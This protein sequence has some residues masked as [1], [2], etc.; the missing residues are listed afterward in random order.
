MAN[1]TEGGAKVL[2]VDDNPAN[3]TAVEA[4]L[5]PL[6]VPLVMARSG[7]MALHELLEH[8]FAVVLLDVMMPGITGLDVARMMR[9]RERTRAVPII[10]LTA[11]DPDEQEIIEGYLQGAAD[12]LVK[13]FD[14][15]MLR[16]KVSVFV[17]L[18]RLRQADR[19]LAREEGLRARAEQE[20]RR[21]HRLLIHAPVAVAV[22]A[23]PDHT[24]ELA[25]ER[26]CRLANREIPVGRKLVEIFPELADSPLVKLL[27][28]IYEKREPFSATE[29]P[30]LFDRNR[31]GKLVQAYFDFNIE[32]LVDEDGRLR[33]MGS[34]LD[35]T[36]HVNARRARDDFLE[37]SHP[38]S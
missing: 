17:E 26:F 35:V 38:T 30:V 18:F 4:V 5:V 36:E 22:M 7:E 12:Y 25:N 6:G 19:R 37:A 3:L 32:P 20:R 23:G 10:F 16:A 11:R 24:F 2:V 9:E 15:D 31:D 14:P 29:F 21:F 28:G 33:L 13:P 27:D 1:T 34:A 8:E